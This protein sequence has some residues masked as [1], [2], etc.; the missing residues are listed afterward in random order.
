M[1]CAASA[2]AQTP[3]APPAPTPAPAAAAPQRRTVVILDDRAVKD[4]APPAFLA[5]VVDEVTKLRGMSVVRFSEARK[6]LAPKADQAL[7][8]C[9]DDPGCLAAAARG[10]GGDIVITVR[11]TKRE[12]AFFLAVTRVN[13]LRPQIA[14]DSGTLAGN[15]ADALAAV[16]EAVAELFPDTETR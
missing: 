11:M 14:D 9:G 8:G 1:L 7:S 2:L 15:D 3:V 6:R 10:A 4:Q 12:G 5:R 13:A 16:P